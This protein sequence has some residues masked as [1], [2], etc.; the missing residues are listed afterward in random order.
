MDSTLDSSDSPRDSGTTA[1]RVEAEAQEGR[2]SRLPPSPPTDNP[3][4]ICTTSR[5]SFT[6]SSK[7]SWYTMLCHAI[8][9]KN[10]VL[11]SRS[12]KS[13]DSLRISKT[14]SLHHETVIRSSYRYT[15]LGLKTDRQIDNTPC[16]VE[17][18][19]TCKLL[20]TV[21]GERQ[22]AQ[23]RTILMPLELSN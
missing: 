1:K 3:S 15:I 4:Y 2:K 13:A 17:S 14:P 21:R 20:G 7:R 18:C 5:V 23:T 10:Q 6:G 11:T 9:T 12:E 16:F 19:I 8:S 22:P